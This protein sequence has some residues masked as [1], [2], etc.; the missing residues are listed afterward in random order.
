MANSNNTNSSRSSMFMYSDGE[1]PPFTSTNGLAQTTRKNVLK[2]N[3][4]SK[5][6][7]NHMMA[8]N[9]GKQ[10]NH[11]N[12]GD[13]EYMIRDYLSHEQSLR[14]RHTGRQKQTTRD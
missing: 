2:S 12:H 9:H 8:K 10:L 4:Q 1:D 3:S 11:G 5:F 14:S 13:R 7:Q 6:M